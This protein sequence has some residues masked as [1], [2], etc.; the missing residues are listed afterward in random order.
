MQQAEENM[1]RDV[2]LADH[3]EYRLQVWDL[4]ERL[5][6]G[7]V[8]AQHRLGYRLFKGEEVIFEGDDYG[9]SPM[10]AIDSDESLAELLSFLTLKPGDTDDEYFEGHSRRQLKWCESREAEEISWYALEDHGMAIRFVDLF[11]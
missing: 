6:V 4:N 10:L 2:R 9:C 8:S 11:S 7:S 1:L 3:P 5:F